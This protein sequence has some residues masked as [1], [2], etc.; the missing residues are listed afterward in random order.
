MEKVD[1][2]DDDNTGCNDPA[3]LFGA[4]GFRWDRSTLPTSVPVHD[5]NRACFRLQKMLAEYV[6]DASV[7][8]GNPFTFPTILDGVTVGGHKLSDQDQVRNRQGYR[9]SG[10]IA[11]RL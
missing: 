8:E 11:E 2:H 5:V 7:L 9:Q 3:E 1:T 6:R 10:Q 4:L